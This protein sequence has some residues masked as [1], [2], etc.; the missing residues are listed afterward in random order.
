HYNSSAFS[1]VIGLVIHPVKHVAV[2]FNRIQGL[3]AGSVV[4]STYVNAGQVFAPYESTQYEVGAKYDIGRFSAG[5]AFYQTSMPYGVV[6]AYG[7]TGQL[8]Y[9]QNGQERNRGM[10]LT[11]NGEIIRGLRFNGGLTLIDAK[12]VR[13]ASADNNGKTAIGV[14]NYTINGNLE[15]DVPFVKGLTLVG[16][17]ISTGKQQFNNANSA[18][19]P[20]WSRFDLGA[21]YTFLVRGKAL[22]TRFEVD[23][24]G[25]QRY[26]ASVYQSNLIMGDPETFKFSI[27]ADL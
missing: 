16:R 10:E 18:H 14:P 27:T 20:A 1:P 13:A 7:N 17:V 22:T 23:N 26:W 15:Y 5:V 9:S 6:E 8:L 12:Q 3:S 2:Y 21:R 25:N 4:G 19:L 24:V 11:F